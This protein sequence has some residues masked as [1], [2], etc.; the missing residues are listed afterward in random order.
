MKKSLLAFA[1]ASLFVVTACDSKTKSKLREAEKRIAQLEENY[2]AAQ[3]SLT[4]TEKELSQVRETLAIKE[5][6]LTLLHLEKQHT[7]PAL[8]VEIIKLFSQKGEVKSPKNED[9]RD[10]SGISVFAST[11]KTGVKWLDQ[12]LLQSLY[13]HYLSKEEKDAQG[14][15]QVTEQDVAAFFSEMYNQLAS[16]LKEEQD[17]MVIGYGESATTY[18]IGQRNNIVS[19][20]QLFKSYFGEGRGV[21]QTHYLNID[22]AK[23]ALIQLDDLISPQNQ[24][25]LEDIL[26]EYFKE[27]RQ[28]MYGTA[29]VFVTRA[30]FFVPKNFYF[31]Q[32]GVTFVYPLNSIGIFAEGELEFTASYYELK[33]LINKAYLLGEKDGVEDQPIHKTHSLRQG[34]GIAEQPINNTHSPNEKDGPMLKSI[35]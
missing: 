12:L 11:A 32:D 28:K 18:Y 21:Y 35:F 4:M 25:K 8:Q 14:D 9:R 2:K 26:W 19:F 10:S 33:E 31:S 13:H 27:S 22:I 24:S 5:N 16:S 29:D 23:K 34:D 20:S 30:Q 7:F 1:I 3:S 17:G 6:E 15:K